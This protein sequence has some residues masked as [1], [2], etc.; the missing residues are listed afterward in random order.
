MDERLFGVTE[1]FHLPLLSELLLGLAGFEMIHAHGAPQY[2]AALGDFYSFAETFLH[3]N[4]K[5]TLRG[6]A[7][8]LLLVERVHAF[9]FVFT[10]NSSAYFLVI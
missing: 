5:R 2:L 8:V 10:K 6:C 3:G 4:S 9:Y 1:R 7:L